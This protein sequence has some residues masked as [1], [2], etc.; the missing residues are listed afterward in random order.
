MEIRNTSLGAEQLAIFRPLH[1]LPA[2]LGFGSR[3]D[4][5]AQRSVALAE[6][7]IERV[8]GPVSEISLRAGS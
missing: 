8:S 2:V 6:V 3:L 1:D 7:A 5:V 4:V